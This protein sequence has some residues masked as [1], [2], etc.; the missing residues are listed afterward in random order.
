MYMP[1]SFQPLAQMVTSPL[2][3]RLGSGTYT[4]LPKN[5]R[6]LSTK[7]YPEI[8]KSFRTFDAYDFERQ[9]PCALGKSGSSK[10]FRSVYTRLRQLKTVIMRLL[11]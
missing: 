5:L 4:I 9:V 6:H 7:N 3:K 2:F 10:M 11:E 1:V 8:N